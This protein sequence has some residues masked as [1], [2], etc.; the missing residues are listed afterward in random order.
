MLA[1]VDHTLLFLRLLRPSF[2]ATAKLP[3]GLVHESIDWKHIRRLATK[4][5]TVSL[6]HRTLP[7][8]LNS[9]DVRAWCKLGSMAGFA[10][11][12]MRSAGLPQLVE[13]LQGMSWV[14]LR[15]PVLGQALYGDLMLRPFGDLDLLFAP[16]DVGEA[17]HRID[18]LGA[19]P[20]PG[21]MSDSFFRNYHLHVQRMWK[22]GAAKILLEVHWAIDHP[23]TLFTPDI[24]GICRRSVTIEMRGV[25]V[26][27]PHP[28]DLLPLLCMHVMK[29]AVWLP[30]Q[31][32]MGRVTDLIE[33]GNL[34]GLIDV[35]LLARKI[36]PR[37][38]WDR[39]VDRAS[40]WGAEGAVRTCLEAVEQLWPDSV[41]PN[42]RKRFANSS[43]GR[44]RRRRYVQQRQESRW[45]KTVA[46]QAV[47]RPVRS[48]DLV[49]YLF[50]P[51]NYLRRRYGAD[52]LVRHAKHTA[53]GVRMMSANA[54][55]FA[56][57]LRRVKTMNRS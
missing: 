8:E 51:A 54:V 22:T 27:M 31:V 32:E 25:D 48:L 7:H 10:E 41:D 14:L 34:L 56:R 15:G 28:D 49:E 2:D 20:V 45:M 46:G 52:G 40:S 35:A 17:L 37:L 30:M 9:K 19:I 18:Q 44:W 5:R 11:T 12:T 23:Y 21:A 36:S 39:V 3:D 50:P 43:V 57:E 24:D 55:A 1:D 53:S 47:F 33:E 4:T 26:P 29:H 38:C 13:A 6:L 42:I 16:H